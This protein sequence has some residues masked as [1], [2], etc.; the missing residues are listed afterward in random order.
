MHYEIAICED[1]PSERAFLSALVRSWAKQSGC[2]AG[3]ASFE[4]AEAFLFECAGRPLDILILDI[5]M[6]QM[7]GVAL[8]KR[9]RAGNETVQII[10]VTGYSDYISDGYD[11]GALH[12]L[13]KP[14]DRDKFF[15]VLDRAAQKLRKNERMLTLALPDETVRVPLYEIRFLDVRQN[16]ATVHG[17]RDYTVKK[18]LRELEP[19]LD[20]RFFRIGRSCILNL[21]Y[22]QRVTRTDVYLTDGSVLPL[23]RGMYEP[24]NRAIIDRM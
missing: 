2:S 3:L 14:V 12:Y 16:Y 20:D 13:M 23:P 7:D 1:Q 22:I 6:G 18:T 21:T 8:A 9:V 5:E 10:F 15:R 19:L 17:K 11:V 24:L 4:S